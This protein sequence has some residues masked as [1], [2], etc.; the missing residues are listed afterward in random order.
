MWPREHGA[1]GQ[2]FCPLLT[3][4]AVAGVARPSVFTTTAIAAM[5]LAHEPL[6]MLLGHRG[7]RDQT[8]QAGR[9]WWSL[10]I[11]LM[12]A[13]A[14]GVLAIDATH[15]DLRWTFLLP[16]VPAI[17]LL[18]AIVTGRE[19]TLSAEVTVA[20]A[21][22]G[23][24]IPLCAGTGHVTAGIVIAAAYALVFILGTLTVRVII[25]RTRGGG[26]PAAV[27]RT[28]LATF[29]VAMLGALIALAG[30]ANGVV[31]W[32]AVAAIVPAIA[33][34]MTLAAYP[35][36]ATRLKKVGWSLV[37]VTVATAVLLVAAV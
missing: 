19:K 17:W 36:P 35:P 5:F 2:A 22:A 11:C 4:F 32:L 27:H 25:L 37:A 1:Y 3:A 31:S 7:R 18:R 14:S 29:A 23:A 10:M 6:V 8:A 9:A 21:F 30:A 12:V 13:T 26:N 33:F 16:A 28:R 34:A 20:L 24:A 15:P